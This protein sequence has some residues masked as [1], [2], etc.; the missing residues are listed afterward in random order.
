MSIETKKETADQSV[1]EDKMHGVLL[2]DSDIELI[3]TALT[4]MKYRCENSGDP[5]VKVYARPAEVLISELN[6][7]I[8]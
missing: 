6:E 4:A 3:L 8:Q 2:F 7:I 5:S 1:V